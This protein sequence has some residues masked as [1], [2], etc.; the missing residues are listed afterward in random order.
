MTFANFFSLD[1]VAPIEFYDDRERTTNGIHPL[2]EKESEGGG[3][4]VN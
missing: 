4:V 1:V 3:E 2:G